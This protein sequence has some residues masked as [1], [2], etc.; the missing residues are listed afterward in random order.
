[1]VD[2]TTFVKILNIWEEPLDI[3]TELPK[4]FI[5]ANAKVNAL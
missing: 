4:G 5:S 1:M 3:A 2:L